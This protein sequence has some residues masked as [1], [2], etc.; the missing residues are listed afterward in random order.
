MDALVTYADFVPS[1]PVAWTER[2]DASDMEL[3]KV[4]DLVTEG[5]VILDAGG[6]VSFRSAVADRLL[7]SGPAALLAG[8]AVE[9]LAKEVASTAAPQERRLELSIPTRRDLLIRGYPFR[10]G[11]VV[12]II[13]DIS[14]R[15][16]FE[17]VRRDFVANV[18]H[19]LKTPVGALSLLAEAL[20]G[21]DDPE[22]VVRLAARIGQE[23]ERLVRIIDDLLDLSRIEAGVPA[24]PEDVPV[25]SVVRESIELIAPVAA[26]LGVVLHVD[27]PPVVSVR[28]DRR[29][30]VSALSNLIDNAVK[31]SEPGGTVTVVAT[32]EE[33][34]VA[35]AVEDTGVGIPARD[36]ER[37]F[38]RFYR[39]DR[40]R[41]RLT[42]GTGLG[43]SIV[44]HVAANHGGNVSVE[45]VEG[46]GSKF[47]LSLPLSGEVEAIAGD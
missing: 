42:G 47:T 31:Y 15:Q 2:P 18:S 38:E 28:G 14:E 29:D 32:V 3:G 24:E 8:D 16:R 20:D 22:V 43:L 27:E 12:A 4:L 5:V 41:S 6:E 11:S 45:S 40:A 33:G 19:E 34:R 39:V 17:S 1:Y 10:E 25:P 7:G 35:L 13:E 23:S 46:E 36:L 26:S 30:L 37:I 44:R 21:E 9:E